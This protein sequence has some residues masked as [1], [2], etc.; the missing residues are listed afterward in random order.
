MLYLGYAPLCRRRYYIK[1]RKRSGCQ[2]GYTDE[3]AA[4]TT[5]G[6]T[7]FGRC[8]GNATRAATLDSMR[9]VPTW[10]HAPPAPWPPDT[11]LASGGTVSAGCFAPTAT[12]TDEAR[13]EFAALIKL[14]EIGEECLP[15]GQ[16]LTDH[17][18]RFRFTGPVRMLPMGK[19]PRN[20]CS[21]LADRRPWSCISRDR[22]AWPSLSPEHPSPLQSRFRRTPDWCSRWHEEQ[23][24]PV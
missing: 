23:P 1:N 24:Y 14:L 7:A 21:Q 8:V 18:A 6:P 13:A 22:Q 16:A 9:E 19:A 11:T 17:S 20:R 3:G 15:H 2:R 10:P 12:C 5:R 4:A